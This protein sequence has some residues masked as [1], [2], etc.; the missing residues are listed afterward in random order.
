MHDFD[1]S[2]IIPIKTSDLNQN[3][4]RPLNSTLDVSKIKKIIDLEHPTLDYILKIIS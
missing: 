3:A 4:K 1:Y 2:R